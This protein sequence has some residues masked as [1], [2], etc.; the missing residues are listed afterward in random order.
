MLLVRFQ[1]RWMLHLK[2]GDAKE[3]ENEVEEFRDMIY[4]LKEHNKARDQIAGTRG[5]TDLW[6]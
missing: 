6:L 1:E 3:A 4:K 2:H 5:A